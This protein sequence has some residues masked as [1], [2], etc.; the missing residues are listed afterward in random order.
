MADDAD[1][2][3]E[4]LAL[5]GEDGF[6]T[7]VE[8]YAGLRLYVPANLDRS[9]LPATV[10]DD[11]ANR[12][13]KAW[14]GGYI[15]VPLAREFRIRRYVDAQMSN[16]DIARRFGVTESGVEKLLKRLKKKQPMKP[17]KRKDSRQI[18]MF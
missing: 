4:L 3:E 2:A 13:A 6:F 9:E 18:E 1:L 14:P 10:G 7:L 16:R 12:L 11:L 17:R 5:L 15:R 8:A